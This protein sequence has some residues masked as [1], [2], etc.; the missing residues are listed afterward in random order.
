MTSATSGPSGSQVTSGRVAPTGLYAV[1]AMRLAGDGKH[2]S[3]TSSTSSRPTPVAGEIGTS[4]KKVA[5]ATAA[6]RSTTVLDRRGLVAVGI[7]L[8]ART[9]RRVEHP[10]A[11]QPHRPD[12]DLLGVVDGQVERLRVPERALAPRDGVVVVGP[13]HVELAHG[14]GPGHADRRELLPQQCGRTVDVV[15]GRDDEDRR[16]RGPQAGP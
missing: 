1:G 8:H 2:C 11:E 3:M 5:L 7:P 6:L 9:V 12:D 10:L 4:G 15:G 13:G 16:V 14:D